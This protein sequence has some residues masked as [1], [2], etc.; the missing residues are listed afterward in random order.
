MALSRRG[1]F[2]TLAAGGAA[3]GGTAASAHEKPWNSYA[4]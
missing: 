1:F 4:S 3:L 2:K